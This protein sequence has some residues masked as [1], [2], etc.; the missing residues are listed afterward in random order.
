MSEVNSL[1]DLLIGRV[2][3]DDKEGRAKLSRIDFE[4]TLG[5]DC[6]M[7][8]VKR[9]ERKVALY[10]AASTS[11]LG[12][13]SMDMLLADPT[14]DSVET[15]AEYGTQSTIRNT[16]RRHHTV[17]KGDK[18]KDLFGHSTVVVSNGDEPELLGAIEEIGRKGLELFG[19]K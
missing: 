14:R 13:V 6:T 15:E 1:S 8:D 4:E 3:R 7:A 9:V 18:R 19:P 10:R 17:G 12:R 2:K 11:A 16:I 5:D